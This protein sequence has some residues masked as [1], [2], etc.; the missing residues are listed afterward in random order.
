[1][2]GR[3]HYFYNGLEDE[4]NEEI[5]SNF[6][7]QYYIGKLNIQSKIMLKYNIED[8]KLIEVLLTQSINKKVEI[9]IPQKGEKLRLVEMAE[10]NAEITLKNKENDKYSIVN[11]LKEVLNLNKVPRKIET[12][13]ISNI[14]GEF[15]V[16][17]MS[18]MIDGVIKKNLARRFKIK[19]VYGQD[20]PKCMNEVITRRLKQSIENPNGGFGDL[21]DLILVDGGVTQIRAAQE[22]IS[23]LGLNISVFGMVKNDKHQTRALINNEKKEF[24]IS[25][26]LLKTIT[27]FQDSV[28]NEAIGYH[29]KLRDASIT[30][31]ALDEI[32]GIGIMKKSMLLKKFGSVE[33]IAKASVEDIL[34]IK[35]INESLAINIK[36]IL[37]KK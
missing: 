32:K 11:E 26:E 31:S 9:K 22:A 36:E 23:S 7:K 15:M 21:P 16:A 34:S 37:N 28:H 2:I 30:K 25:E 20:D 6:L 18:V 17:G 19:T 8:L 1:M 24:N 3:E 33:N 5:I 35:G 13:D 4:T 14:S 10:K 12:F 27:L 29:R